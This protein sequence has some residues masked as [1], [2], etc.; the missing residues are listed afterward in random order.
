MAHS[1]VRDLLPET[2]GRCG[3]HH[4]VAVALEHQLA[5]AVSR[6]HGAAL[7]Q[8]VASRQRGHSLLRVT[9]AIAALGL[10][11]QEGQ[12]YRISRQSTECGCYATTPI[13]LALSSLTETLAA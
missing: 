13:I 8:R 5:L 11:E 4:N 2:R 6:C 7:A 12:G 10:Q 3:T 9:I 1:K